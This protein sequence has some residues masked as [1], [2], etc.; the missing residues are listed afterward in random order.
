MIYKKQDKDV[1]KTIKEMR[2]IMKIELIGCNDT[3][4]IVIY[5]LK[6]YFDRLLSFLLWHR[7]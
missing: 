5:H 1:K 2:N 4:T 6:T 7:Y 3:K